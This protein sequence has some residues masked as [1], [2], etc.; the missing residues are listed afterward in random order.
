MT[1]DHIAW[2]VEH[3]EKMGFDYAESIT[4]ANTLDD[5]GC[6]LYWA[7]VALLLTATKWNHAQTLDILA[8][9]PGRVIEYG[10]DG[11]DDGA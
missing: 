1:T 3:Y 4:L 6:P 7:D 2:R 5:K 11:A 10:G 9:L 8:G